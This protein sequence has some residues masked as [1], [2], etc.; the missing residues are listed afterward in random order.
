MVRQESAPKKCVTTNTPRLAKKD[1]QEWILSQ[2]EDSWSVK[3][4]VRDLGGHLD[5][6]LR[7]W[8]ATLATRFVLAITRLLMVAVPPLDFH[9]KLRVV[10]TI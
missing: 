2:K 6:T 10:R 4:D 5:T 8:S 1:M 3:I 7:G 9:W